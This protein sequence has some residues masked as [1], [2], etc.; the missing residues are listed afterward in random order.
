MEQTIIKSYATYDLDWDP[1]QI[2]TAKLQI[3]Q[4]KTSLGRAYL[5][6]YKFDVTKYLEVLSTFNYIDSLA[7]ILF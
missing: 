2:I 4:L 1:W 3:L 7:D 5:S 6:Y